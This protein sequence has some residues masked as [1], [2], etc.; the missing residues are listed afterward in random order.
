MILSLPEIT[1]EDPLQARLVVV[2]ERYKMHG[3]NAGFFA[4][5]EL[6]GTSANQ[7]VGTLDDAVIQFDRKR[8]VQNLMV[9][10]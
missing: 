2:V 5:K 1:N 3:S 8:I 7:S 6:I 9:T 10:I 4:C